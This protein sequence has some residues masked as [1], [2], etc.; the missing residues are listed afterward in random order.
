MAAFGILEIRRRGHLV[1]RRSEIAFG[2][3][4][5]VSHRLWAVGGEPLFVDALWGEPLGAT[6][7]FGFYPL[8][9]E[10]LRGGAALQRNTSIVFPRN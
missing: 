10:A 9:G 8:W 1:I 7:V 2:I 4:Q 3:R 6:R 5:I